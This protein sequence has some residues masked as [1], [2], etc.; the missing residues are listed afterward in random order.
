MM[1]ANVLSLIMLRSRAFVFEFEVGSRVPKPNLTSSILPSYCDSQENTTI[2]M[3][4]STT[5]K[6]G[7]FEPKNPVKLDPPKDDAI[8][9]EQLAKCDGKQDHSKTSVT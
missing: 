5:E 7:K 9:V 8:S 3:S 6:K 4:E 2:I 1:N